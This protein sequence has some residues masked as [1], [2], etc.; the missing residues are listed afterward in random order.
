MQLQQLGVD[1]VFVLTHPL[2]KWPP[3]HQTAVRS[4]DRHL[5]HV[6]EAETFSFHGRWKYLSLVCLA[7]GGG[8]LLV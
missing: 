2:C 1:S 4:S 5:L 6:D 3:P 7:E 8:L